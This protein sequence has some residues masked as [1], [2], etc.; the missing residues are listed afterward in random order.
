V[1]KQE[2]AM[3]SLEK[4]GFRFSN[5]I[6]TNPDANNV[7]QADQQTALMVKRSKHGTE[8]REVSPDGSI[9]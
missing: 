4:Q 7:D 1:N 3:A 8:Y 9:N 6:A 5:W 2:S